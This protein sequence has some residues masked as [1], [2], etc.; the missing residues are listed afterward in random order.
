[1]PFPIKH[2][3]LADDDADDV[4]MFQSAVDEIC[5]DIK[6]TVAPDGVKLISLLNKIS[7]ADAIFLDLNMPRKTGK[8]CLIE[9]RKENKY[10]GVPIVILSTS[11]NKADIDYCLG[12]GAN[13]YFVKPKSFKELKIIVQKLCN[14]QLNIKE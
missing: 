10:N 9:I 2:I 11:G 12:N 14:G 5:P 3:L 8:E 13:Y 7:T 6:I 1:M 4:E